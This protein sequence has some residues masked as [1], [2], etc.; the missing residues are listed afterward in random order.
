MAKNIFGITLAR[1]QKQKQSILNAVLEYI[2]CL[3]K[4]YFA[5][6]GSSQK[7]ETFAISNLWSN[8][9]F[10]PKS[11]KT[12]TTVEILTWYRIQL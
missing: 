5:S 9:D 11:I 10:I 6:F 2:F 7:E 1:Y 12:L 8:Q 3:K 4:Q